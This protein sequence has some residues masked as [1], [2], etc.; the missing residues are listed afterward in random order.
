MQKIQN[1]TYNVK[2]VQAEDIAA[3][4]EELE[5]QLEQA[6]REAREAVNLMRPTYDRNVNVEQC[7]GGLVIVQ[8]WYGVFGSA[9]KLIDVTVPVQCL[10][11]N[12]RLIL[13]EHT[14]VFTSG[15]TLRA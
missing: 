2:P 1:F 10:V 11:S 6:K 4:S 13:P 7:K 5:T 15:V 3:R 12:S 9:N 8:A 14:K